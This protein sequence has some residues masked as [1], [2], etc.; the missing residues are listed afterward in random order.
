[1]LI[2]GVF[3]VWLVV[4][5]AETWIEMPGWAWRATAGVLGVAWICAYDWKHWWYGVG[6][7]GAAV[8][9]AL[10]TDLLLVLT[11]WARVQVLHR[12][13]PGRPL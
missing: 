7:G 5:L 13:R 2:L 9:L 11:D 6:I 1:M 10:V 8:A 4:L 3:A 12:T